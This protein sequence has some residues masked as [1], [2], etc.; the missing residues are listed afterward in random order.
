M[1]KAF[2]LC[3]DKKTLLIFI[4]LTQAALFGIVLICL[5]QEKR[6]GV[7]NDNNKFDIDLAY[8]QVKEKELAKILFEKKIEVK[9]DKLWKK[10][11][12]IAVEFK[13][14]G[15]PSGI[16]VSEAEFYAFILDDSNTINSIIILP[17]GRLKDI[18]R[19][20]KKIECLVVIII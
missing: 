9:S 20:H 11:S 14:N 10:T 16:S 15:K 6:F 12:N 3:N 19:K 13:C 18:A 7:Y 8:G 5:K 2:E 17:T 1:N 4:N